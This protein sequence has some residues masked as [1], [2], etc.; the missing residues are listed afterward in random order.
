MKQAN[1]TI[2][3]HI[4]QIEHKY[5]VKRH[6]DLI[7]GMENNLIIKSVIAT[8]FVKCKSYKYTNSLSFRVWM[9]E[10]GP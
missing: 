4:Q 9:R 8:I 1:N 5:N 6:V 3:L 7:F 10:I 2:L